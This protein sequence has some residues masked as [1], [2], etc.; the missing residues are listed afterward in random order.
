ME[1]DVP[2]CYNGGR[3]RKK[4]GHAV[5]IPKRVIFCLQRLQSAGSAFLVGGCVRDMLLGKPPN[6]WDI[7]TSLTPQAVKSLFAD[8]PV[9]DTGLQFGTVTVLCDHLPIEVTTFRG[10]GRYSDARHPDEVIFV[11]RIED[12]LSR[13]DFTVNAMAMDDAGTIVDPFSGREDLQKKVI[14]CVGNPPDRLNEDPLRVLRGVRFACNLGFSIEEHTKTALKEAAPLLQKISAERIAIE[15]KKT[16]AAPDLTP[17]CDLGVELVRGIF[18]CSARREYFSA[19]ARSAT[20]WPV[21]LAIFVLCADSGERERL[22]SSLKPDGETYHDT[23]GLLRAVQAPP[24]L[25][26]EEDARVYFSLAGK[27]HTGY[28]AALFEALESVN[29]AY[30]A[31]AHLLNSALTSAAPDGL[32]ELA[33]TGDDLLAMGFYEGRQT[34]DALRALLVAA[35]TRPECNRKDMLESLALEM[36][37]IGGD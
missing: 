33:V 19:L 27:R 34:G 31:S 1:N 22:L 32:R 6:D 10:E 20:E 37:K 4:G 2:R 35:A 15:L 5:E 13:R 8:V 23:L 28:C 3:R 18:G 26:T 17:F 7:A 16:F 29:K 30:A 11:R 12:D 25:Q 24:S 9:I 14:R 21:R 36:L